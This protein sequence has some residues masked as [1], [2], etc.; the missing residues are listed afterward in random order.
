MAQKVDVQVNV[1][2]PS[3]TVEFVVREALM[4]KPQKFTLP[5]WIVKKTA[6][7]ILE[8][9]VTQEVAGPPGRI[10]AATQEEQHALKS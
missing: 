3:R 5:F 1:D 9:E 10:A 7:A 8:V 6:G 2:P 4:L